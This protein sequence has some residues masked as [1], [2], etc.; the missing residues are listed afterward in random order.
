MVLVERRSCDGVVPRFMIALSNRKV[1]VFAPV[2]E[3]MIKNAGD[4]TDYILLFRV[5]LHCMD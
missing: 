1:T 4:I 3:V 2:D 5:G